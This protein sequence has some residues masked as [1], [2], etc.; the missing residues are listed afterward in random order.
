M[1]L[2][3]AV[4]TRRLGTVSAPVFSG[5]RAAIDRKTSPT[6]HVAET[7]GL[8]PAMLSQRVGV[9]I[10]WVAAFTSPDHRRRASAVEGCD[11]EI[12]MVR[13]SAPFAISDWDAEPGLNTYDTVKPSRVSTRPEYGAK[14]ALGL[15]SRT[16]SALNPSDTRGMRRKG[17]NGNVLARSPRSSPQ[18]ADTHNSANAAPL[19][20]FMGTSAPLRLLSA[21]ARPVPAVPV[22]PAPER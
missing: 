7:P 17:V 4:Y 6:C 9:P 5:S 18:P 15:S 11:A 16:D 12:R 14:R 20:C 19:I 10:D 13:S 2:C 21:P 1:G 22:P 8:A 3:A